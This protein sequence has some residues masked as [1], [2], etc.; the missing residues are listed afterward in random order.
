[1]ISKDILKKALNKDIKGYALRVMIYLVTSELYDDNLNQI[2]VT[3]RV[4]AK[5]LDIEPSFVN[6]AIAELR[7]NNVLSVSKIGKRNIYSFSK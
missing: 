7:N 6:K 5:D 3:Q 2:S 4:I 1:M